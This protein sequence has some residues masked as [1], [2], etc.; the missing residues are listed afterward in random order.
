MFLVRVVTCIAPG[1]RVVGRHFERDRGL[2]EWFEYD[3]VVG[4]EG[5]DFTAPSSSSF[6]HVGAMNMMQCFCAVGECD[7]VCEDCSEH[8]NSACQEQHAAKPLQDHQHS[9]TYTTQ[10]HSD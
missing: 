2:C 9:L 10:A 5:G 6:R 1:T 8:W 3:V 4:A 7:V